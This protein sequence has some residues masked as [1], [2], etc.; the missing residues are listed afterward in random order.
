[1][2]HNGFKGSLYITPCET[3]PL[4]YIKKNSVRE[5]NSMNEETNLYRGQIL[6][7]FVNLFFFLLVF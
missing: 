5:Q 6:F 3:L 4:T 7:Y 2:L 1:M